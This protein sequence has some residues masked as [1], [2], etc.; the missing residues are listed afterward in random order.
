MKL[1]GTFQYLTPRIRTKMLNKYSH[2]TSFRGSIIGHSLVNQPV[3]ILF[4]SE[5]YLVLLK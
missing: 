1:D 2:P 4:L 5:R 3:S